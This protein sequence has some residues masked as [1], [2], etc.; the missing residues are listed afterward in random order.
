MSTHTNKSRRT[1]IRQSLL[2]TAGLPLFTYACNNMPEATN[3]YLDNIGLQLYTVRDQLA[4]DPA[5]TFK[6]LKEI[7]YKQVEMMQVQ[8]MDKLMPMI[9]DNGL[10]VNGAFFNWNY[11][12]GNWAMIGQ[13]APANYAFENIVEDAQKEQ[14][15]YL[16]FGY[17][18]KGERST[19]DD[20]KKLIDTLNKAG[21][22][23]KTAGLQLAYHN[24]SFEFG[25]VEGQ[26][27]FEM[28]VEG[29]DP[30]L[31]KFELDIF[32]ASIGG[33]DPVQTINR[34]GK[35]IYLL[36]LKDKLKGTPVIYDEREVPKD[37]FKEL[38]NGVVDIRACMEA[39]EKLGVAHCHVEQDQ[40]PDPLNSVAQ[41]MT[42]LKG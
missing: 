30:E 32:W 39:A 26:V 25:S 13:E 37:A 36:H 1:F 7:G 6:T 14:L 33:Y 10:Q 22:Q 11:L 9:R 18:T 24:H 38:G 28:L 29:L 12:T 31:V 3:K 27:P 42:W 16:V 2:A 21:E 23:C 19:L 20:W 40:S 17:I 4:E 34:L 35:R 8:G 41:S 5:T 15:E